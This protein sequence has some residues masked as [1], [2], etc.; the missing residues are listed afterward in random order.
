MVKGCVCYNY[1]TLIVSCTYMLF[2]KYCRSAATQ[3]E[4]WALIVTIDLHSA[5]RQKLSAGGGCWPCNSF[6]TSA[7]CLADSKCCGI[8]SRALDAIHH[9]YFGDNAWMVG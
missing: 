6:S 1:C 8:V 3:E 2:Y 7:P 9:V 4:M 5:V